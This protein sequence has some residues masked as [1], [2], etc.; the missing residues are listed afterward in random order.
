MY[1]Q[2]MY[3]KLQSIASTLRLGLLSQPTSITTS[4]SP[5]TATAQSTFTMTAL[6]LSG[7]PLPLASPGFVQAQPPLPPVRVRLLLSRKAIASVLATSARK[8]SSTCLLCVM[9]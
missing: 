6:S 5:R 7:T 8:A 4:P 9:V 3:S 1:H 2:Y